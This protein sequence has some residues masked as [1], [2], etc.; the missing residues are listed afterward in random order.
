[1]K[2]PNPEELFL[3]AVRQEPWH[4]AGQ[5][6]G[7]AAEDLHSQH[8]F[9][10]A[11]A[12]HQAG[13]PAAQHAHRVRPEEGQAEGCGHRDAA[14]VVQPGRETG[15]DGLEGTL[16]LLT[17]FL[18]IIAIVIIIIIIRIIIIIIIIIIVV[19]VVVVVV[20]IIIDLIIIIIIIITTWP[21]RHSCQDSNLTQ[22]AAQDCMHLA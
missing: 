4:Q 9:G 14:G 5:G 1:L 2:F 12:G 19:F 7:G 11:G 6:R 22:G 21:G 20:I 8:G 17:L 3:A 13:G 10:A 16:L 18:I 15:H